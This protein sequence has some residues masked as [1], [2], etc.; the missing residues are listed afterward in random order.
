MLGYDAEVA[1]WVSMQLSASPE[2]SFGP[3]RAIG[4][5]DD[6]GL[7]AG[8]VYSDHRE[9]TGDIEMTISARSPRWAARGNIRALLHYPFVQL[10]CSRAT[11]LVRAGNTR[12][13]KLAEGLGFVQEGLKRRGFG[14][15]D[16]VIYGML[17]EEAARWL[18]KGETR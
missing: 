5:A 2:H 11:V 18:L 14:D 7:I 9:E 10:G 16:M 6:T 15:D 1:A 3:C 8:V 12:S 13:R 17:R 4:V